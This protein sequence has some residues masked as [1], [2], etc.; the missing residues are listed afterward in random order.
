MSEKI[1]DFRQIKNEKEAENKTLYFFKQMQIINDLIKQG[2]I[3][4][5]FVIV[6]TKNRNKVATGNGITIRRGKEMAR[7]FLNNTKDYVD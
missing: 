5:I 3:E 7:D 6:E 1:L 4:D 2:E